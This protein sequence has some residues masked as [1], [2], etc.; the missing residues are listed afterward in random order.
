MA[1]TKSDSGSTAQAPDD[2]GQEVTDQPSLGACDTAALQ[3]GTVGPEQPGNNSEN[4]VTKPPA[5]ANLTEESQAAS[6][7]MQSSEVKKAL[8]KENRHHDSTDQS[9]AE[10]I[11]TIVR[12]DLSDQRSLCEPDEVKFAASACTALP[13]DSEGRG[14]EGSKSAS[15][16]DPQEAGDTTWLRGRLVAIDA[17]ATST[18]HSL[19]EQWELDSA[20]AI[21]S[22]ARAVVDYLEKVGVRESGSNLN[23]RDSRS[24]KLAAQSPNEF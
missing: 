20:A 8:S 10:A 18:I 11:D 5:E 3:L 2:S 24:T 4:T 1:T 12:P 17:Q 23:S 13:Q 21:D 19:M 22:H 7:A 15:R 14:S 16:E 9:V 6:D